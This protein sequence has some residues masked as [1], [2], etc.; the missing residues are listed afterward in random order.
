[1]WLRPQNR[2]RKKSR[3]IL[4]ALV[5]STA[6]TGMLATSLDEAIAE[7]GLPVTGQVNYQSKTNEIVFDSDFPG[8]KLDELVEV[9]PN[10]FDVVIRPETEPINDSAW[11]AFRVKASDER[12]ID[13]R[14]CYRGGSH[15]YEPKISQDRKEW[16]SAEHLVVARHPA[17]REITL[18]LPVGPTPTWI[19]GQE[20]HGDKDLN[21][22]MNRYESNAHVSTSIIGNSVK[23]LP[24]RALEIADGE[25][26][27]A[28][29]IVSRQHPP[30]VTGTIGMMSFVDAIASDSEVAKGFRKQFRTV[31]VPV[32]NPDGVERGYWRT[33]ANGIDL[34]RDWMRFTQPETRA[35]RDEM[36]RVRDAGKLWLFLDFHSTYNEVFFTPPTETKLFP[37][38]FTTQWLAAVDRRV[39]DFDVIHDDAH[40]AHRTTSKSWVSRELGIHAI[41]YEFGDETE[42]P[43]I[44][45]IAHE[46]ADEMMKLLLQRKRDLTTN[47]VILR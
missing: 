29:F 6:F 42:R 38:G 31:V 8:G 10:R 11:Y 13:V 41:T 24:L 25:P 37:E 1:M 44:H 39:K 23:G 34:N 5:A 7:P 40:N 19:A 17:G 46:S 9:N 26:A 12:S 33:N 22:W 16:K 2:N 30:E 18:R 35:I 15:R 45:R 14:L 32:A 36:L 21:R 43:K 28:I 27:D 4:A 47:D 20:L 3:S